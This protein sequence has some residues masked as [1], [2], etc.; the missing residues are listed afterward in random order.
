ME[1]FWGETIEPLVLRNVKKQAMFP[2]SLFFAYP[3]IV[4]PIR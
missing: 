1:E 4:T 3:S 2:H